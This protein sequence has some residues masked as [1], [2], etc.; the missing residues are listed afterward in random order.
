[1]L[2]CGALHAPVQDERVDPQLA[3]LLG[4]RGEV[5]L[6]L[7]EDQAMTA[8]RELGGHVVGDL[9]SAFR[10]LGDRAQHLMDGRILGLIERERGLVN[11]ELESQR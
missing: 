8:C 11:L 5:G 7:A 4:E 1:M 2:L 10:I 9:A 6:A 3:Q